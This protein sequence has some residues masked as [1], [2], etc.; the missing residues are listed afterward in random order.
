MT[1][2]IGRVETGDNKM[3]KAKDLTIL[4]EYTDK[5]VALS[6]DESKVISSGDTAREALDNS[7]RLG[8]KEPIL[9]KVPSCYGT[10][11]LP[12]HS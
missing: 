11:I 5:W 1:D 9:T 10:F 12:A 2:D 3:D 7:I 8:E 6:P 4:K